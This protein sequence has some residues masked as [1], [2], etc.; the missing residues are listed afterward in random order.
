MVQ[1]FIGV[2]FFCDQSSDE[3]PFSVHGLVSLGLKSGKKAGD[4]YSTY[5]EVSLRGPVFYRGFAFL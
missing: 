2:L 3:S 5:N 1:C 4:W